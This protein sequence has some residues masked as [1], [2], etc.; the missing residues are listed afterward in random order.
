VTKTDSASKLFRE[1]VDEWAAEQG[2][3]EIEVECGV[4][5][6]EMADLTK[7]MNA[8]FLAPGEALAGV[9]PDL[10]KGYKREDL[11]RA[12]DERG[13]GRGAY[14]VGGSVSA[15]HATYAPDPSYPEL[16]R[17]AKYQAVTVLWLIV[18]PDGLPHDIRIV[19]PSGMGLDEVAASS[20]SKWRFDPAIKDG[21]RVAVM[22][23][24]EVSFKLY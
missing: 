8:V 1:K 9:L 10:W 21:S 3:I 19:K 2:K 5:Q 15:P 6:P 22:I 16:A 18:D 23:N 17:Q 13:A 7:A 4:T 14:R 20:V 12:K 24:V 11:P